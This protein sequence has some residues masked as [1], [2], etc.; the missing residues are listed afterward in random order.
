MEYYGKLWPTTVL[1]INNRW[2]LVGDTRVPTSCFNHTANKRYAKFKLSFD[3][4][5]DPATIKFADELAWVVNEKDIR[6]GDVEEELVIQY[7]SKWPINN[8][9]FETSYVDP[10]HVYRWGNKTDGTR[11]PR[12]P[13]SAGDKEQRLTKRQKKVNKKQQMETDASETEDDGEK[14]NENEESEGDQSTEDSERE[15][16]NPQKNKPT[17]DTSKQKTR[18]RKASSRASMP[19]KASTEKRGDDE[20][21][22][23]EPK[24]VRASR[25]ASVSAPTHNSRQ[26]H[27][28]RCQNYLKPQTA[29]KC[30]ACE[31][32]ICLTARRC[33]KGWPGMDLLAAHIEHEVIQSWLTKKIKMPNLKTCSK[34]CLYALAFKL[35]SEAENFDEEF[36]QAEIQQFNWTDAYVDSFEP[37]VPS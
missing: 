28:V 27:C 19:Q 14:K 26:L 17:P 35:Q 33:K 12:A 4:Q 16:K 10:G 25:A 3:R 36:K 37:K 18:K 8:A 7:F 2:V 6:L 29:G 23:Q 31:R 34:R 15:P 13:S 9:S 30:R 21:L 5:F 1:E 20:L 24:R 22:S 32:N 11:R